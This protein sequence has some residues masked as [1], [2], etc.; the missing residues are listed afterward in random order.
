MK[1]FNPKLAARLMH[2]MESE[3][4]P[5]AY[6]VIASV[7]LD[8]VRCIYVPNDGFYTKDGN[9]FPA[10]TLAHIQPST[11][12][13]LD[14]ELWN[15]GFSLQNIMSHVMKQNATAHLISYHVFDLMSN[16]IAI[17]RAGH[18]LHGLNV[19]R[20]EH[21]LIRN[22]KEFNDYA[23][24]HRRAGAEGIMYKHAYSPYTA[25]R[26]GE[27][28]KFK[29]FY[30]LELPIL[31]IDDGTGKNSGVASRFLFNHNGVNFWVGSIGYDHTILSGMWLARDRI[32]GKI[33]KIQF[34]GYSKDN[35]PLNT[36]IQTI[37]EYDK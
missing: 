22:E 10:V 7:K 16:D 24:I 11:R 29:F 34:K 35:V 37:Y 15:P 27:L 25:G 30:H 36:V 5:T 19:M 28:K 3:E 4:L 17:V 8:G 23:E 13:I 26:T 9:K 14:G 18:D 20:H 2:G 33:A 1:Q 12:Y 31:D 6:P 21:T 32:I